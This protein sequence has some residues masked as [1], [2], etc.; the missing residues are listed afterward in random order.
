MRKQP[1]K[2][3]V[4]ESTLMDNTQLL[5]RVDVVDEKTMKKMVKALEPHHSAS[6]ENPEPGEELFSTHAIPATKEEREL[7]DQAKYVHIY[8]I[9]E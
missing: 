1:K 6:M 2:Y 7:G 9:G 5:Q 8:F 3:L 4:V